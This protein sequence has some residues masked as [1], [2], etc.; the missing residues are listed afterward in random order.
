MIDIGRTLVFAGLALAVV[1]AVIW[2]A[3]RAGFR[4]LPGDIAYHGETARFYFPIV[5]CIVLSILL[6]AIS[7]IWQWW[8]GR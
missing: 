8:K 4:G 7:W 3:A 2:L 5:T 1:G 6:T